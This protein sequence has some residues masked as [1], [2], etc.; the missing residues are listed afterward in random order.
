MPVPKELDVFYGPHKYMKSLVQDVERTIENTMLTT[1]DEFSELLRHLSQRFHTFKTHEEI[2][3][4]YILQP[5]L[6]RY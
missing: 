6:P 4:L 1:Y 2:E 5:L 3:N